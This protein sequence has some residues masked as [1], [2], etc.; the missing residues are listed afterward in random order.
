MY[1]AIICNV[2]VVITATRCAMWKNLGC[3][4][5]TRGTHERAVRGAKRM[6]ERAGAMVVRD[7]LVKD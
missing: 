2:T 4:L 5:R 7:V 6:N 1:F 3:K